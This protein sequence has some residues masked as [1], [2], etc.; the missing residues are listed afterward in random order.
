MVCLIITFSSLFYPRHVYFVVRFCRVWVCNNIF[1]YEPRNLRSSS[2]LLFLCSS[3]LFPSPPQSLFPSNTRLSFW[4][5][6]PISTFP[7]SLTSHCPLLS[8]IL[9]HFLI[10]CFS[11]PLSPSPFPTRPP[12]HPHYLSGIIPRRASLEHWD[13]AQE[14]F[15]AIIVSCYKPGDA[16]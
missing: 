6:I 14:K 3:L 12:S 16:G 10:P 7:T 1:F 11:C 15:M 4:L 13:N 2:L 5:L 9:T 8:I